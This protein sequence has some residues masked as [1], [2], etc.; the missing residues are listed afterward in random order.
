[1]STILCADHNSTPA[2]PRNIRNYTRRELR[3]NQA[4]CR[5]YSGRLLRFNAVLKP[6][7]HSIAW[8]KVRSPIIELVFDKVHKKL[9]CRLG[10]QTYVSGINLAGFC[11]TGI[12]EYVQ[13]QIDACPTCT[14]AKM[15]I[16][17]VSTLTQNMKWFYGPDDFIANTTHPNPIKI[18][19]IDE[20][21]P[22]YLNDSHGGHNKT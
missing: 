22:F 8:V 19:S 10:P 2:V 1:M 3:I 13:G 14:E 11:A 12:T 16:K 7:W 18:V 9:Y 20:A 4:F 15:V 6:S 21:G 17:G 5:A